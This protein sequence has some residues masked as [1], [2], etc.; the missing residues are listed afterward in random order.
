[1]LQFFTIFTQWSVPTSLYML[2]I[3]LY[4]ACLDLQPEWKDG[5]GWI[6]FRQRH[7]RNLNSNRF[8]DFRPFSNVFHFSTE[9]FYSVKCVQRGAFSGQTYFSPSPSQNR[10]K[11]KLLYPSVGVLFCSREMK[12]LCFPKGIINPLSIGGGK[13]ESRAMSLE[14]SH[15]W[16][17]PF[18]GRNASNSTI[19]HLH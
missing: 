13:L 4:L 19:S 6:L 15:L 14:L 17:N 16:E 1:M 9:E 5:A 10:D 18:C 8:S 12:K 2:E 3:C 7:R 11:N